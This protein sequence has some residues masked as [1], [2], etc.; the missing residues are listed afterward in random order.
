MKAL[1]ICREF[2]YTWEEYRALPQ[3]FVAMALFML[4]EEAAEANRKSKA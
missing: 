3:W 1:L 2:G 4:Q